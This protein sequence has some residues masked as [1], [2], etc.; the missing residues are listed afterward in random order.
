MTLLAKG[1]ARLRDMATPE[2]NLEA[3]AELTV[4]LAKFGHPQEEVVE[5]IAPFMQTR[6]RAE[7]FVHWLTVMNTKMKT[8]FDKVVDNRIA[9]NILKESKHDV[10]M[11]MVQKLLQRGSGNKLLTKP[12]Y[13]QVLLE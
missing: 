6:W 9:E 5:Q 3:I 11:N 4:H 13:I 1:V 12:C 10:L 8:K 7:A 2:D